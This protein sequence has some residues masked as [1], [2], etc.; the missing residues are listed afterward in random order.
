MIKKIT[1]ILFFASSL[2][3]SS[4]AQQFKVAYAS[5]A[6]QKPF[7]GKVFLYL[8][9]NNTEPLTASI[10]FEPLTCFAIDVKNIKSGEDVVIDNHAVSYPVI[11]SDIERGDYYIQAVWDRNLG[12]RSIAASPGN[13]YSKPQKISI[14]KDRNQSFAILADQVVPEQVF[15]ASEFIKELNVPSRLLS[16]FHHKP[17][18]LS[19]AVQL[20]LEYYKNPEKKFPVVFVVFGYGADYHR[21]SGNAG[22]K[23]ISLG[24][25]PVIR[26][27]L[28]GNC[29]LGHSAYANSENNGPWG[30]ALTQELIPLLE[31]KYRCNGARMLMG[32]SSGGWSVLWLQTHYPEVFLA[33]ASSSPDYVDF[34]SFSK[35][36]LYQDSNLYYNKKRAGIPGRDCGGKISLCLCQRD[37]SGRKCYF[38]RRAAALF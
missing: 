21:I 22:M 37:V 29:S 35:V 38:K 16:D 17:F 32:H 12:G 8:S 13:V 6:L 3:L 25:E 34:R 9:K 19:A 1:T 24:S 30:D 23:H 20:P 36:D 7:T 26:V 2:T 18:S 4:F 5:S 33:T 15:T 28:D 27:F 31:Q 10:G 14:S 11:P